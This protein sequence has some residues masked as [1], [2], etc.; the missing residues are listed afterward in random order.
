MKGN[1]FLIGGE[2]I[3]TA[4]YLDNR[5]NYV[6]QT[7]TYTIITDNF[8]AEG[9]DELSSVERLSFADQFVAID[10][11]GNG[12]I[13]A[14]IVG[15]TFDAESLADADFV[16]EVLAQVDAGVSYDSLMVKYIEQ[17]GAF[18]NEEVVDLLFENVVGWLPNEAQSDRFVG[19]LE[20]EKHTVGSLGVLA[21]EHRLN[22]IN[23]DLVGLSQTG[24][25]YAMV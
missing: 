20:T 7:D 25:E 16:G 24:L 2:S 21:A 17:A 11:D 8:G 22:D 18:T 9:T 3:D 12:G 13:A 23:I 1:D 15:A 19:F 4:L 14:K 10:M 6:L 5:G